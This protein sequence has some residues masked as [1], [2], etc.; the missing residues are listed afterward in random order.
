MSDRATVVLVHG[1][2]ETEAVWDPMVAEMG[3]GNIVR[4][5]PPGFGAPIPPGFG[6][7]VAEY[8]DWLVG[9]LEAFDAPV[10]LVGHDWGGNHVVNVAMARP[11]LLRSWATDTIGL[12]DL[13]YVWHDLARAWQTPGEGEELVARQMGGTVEERAVSMVE[14]GMAG[15][16][17]ERLAAGQGEEMGRAILAL[18]RSAA[19]PAMAELGE[20]L[21]AAAARPGLSILATED[22][23]LG[24]EEMRR[25]AAGRAGARTEV[26]GGLG[27]WW[28]VEDPVRGA[29]A[30]E[31][32]WGGLAS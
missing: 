7:T 14:L 10:H 19:Q 3:R 17:A 4:L 12:F 27:H 28:M 15:P 31:D 20:N 32:F 25:R 9:E 24:T 8:R 23:N 6:A 18:Y 16:V 11:D 21:E 2:P 5:S 13:G 30:L 22:E 1:N 29:S 26:L